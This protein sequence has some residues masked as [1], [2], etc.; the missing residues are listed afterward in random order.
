MN[1]DLDAVY[2]DRLDVLFA[3]RNRAYGA[4]QLRRAYPDHLG[5][6]LF[7]GLSLVSLFVILPYLAQAFS[8]VFGTEPPPLNVEII[9][10]EPPDI[11]ATDP[12]EPP[13]VET[14]PPPAR[15]TQ[16]FV[17]PLVVENNVEEAPAATVA[18][19]L[20][21]P[22]DIAGRTQAGDPGAL[23]TLTDLKPNEQAVEAPPAP[24][25]DDGIYTQID[26]QKM[27]VFGAGEADLI[28]YL[29]ENIQYPALARES[30]IQGT[31]VLTFLV[32]KDG[33][34]GDVQILREIGG[35]CG[36]EAVRVVKNMPGWR[37][38]EAN[39][40]PVKVRFTLPVR[41]KLN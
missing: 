9:L 24:A 28:R 11:A 41:F 21:S 32:G 27:P 16:R 2:R 39:G 17:P 29:S 35:G 12:V 18:E 20:E 10:Q 15:A 5:R 7:F 1:H 34:V 36:K 31:V 3:N 37:P 19:L 6:A 13:P 30:N 25:Q 38:G 14:P 40:H 33:R 23:P 26:V 22:D 4:Y 8:R